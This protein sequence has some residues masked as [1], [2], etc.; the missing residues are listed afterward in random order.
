M[1]LGPDDPHPQPFQMKVRT[2][3]ITQNIRPVTRQDIPDLKQIAG[4]T[5]LFPSDMLGDMIAGYLD[6]T[7]PDIWFTGLQDGQPAAFGYCEP[8]R[9]TD[10]TWNLLAIGVLPQ[11]QGQGIGAAMIAHLEATLRERDARILL[12]ET[13]GTPDYAQTRAF[14]AKNGFTE[15]A[16]IRAFYGPDLDKVVF[17]KHL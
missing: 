17:W 13:L 6:G 10:G 15:E 8:E 4:A 14:Y 16:R 3:D 2:L 11:F 7:R 5:G 12:V 9:M 1:A